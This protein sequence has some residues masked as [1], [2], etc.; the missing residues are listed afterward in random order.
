MGAGRKKQTPVISV[1]MEKKEQLIKSSTRAAFFPVASL[2]SCSGSGLLAG[3]EWM[4]MFSF[5]Q[6]GTPQSPQSASDSSNI[7]VGGSQEAIMVLTDPLQ[8]PGILRLETPLVGQPKEVGAKRL[9]AAG[10]RHYGPVGSFSS[11]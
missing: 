1:P 6:V 7:E 11:R 8:N 10:L 2:G 4:W 5:C 9:A 3:G